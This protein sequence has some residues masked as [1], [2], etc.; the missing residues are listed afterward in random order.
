MGLVGF[1]AAALL[2]HRV[3]KQDRA[4]AA[5]A[6]GAPSEVKLRNPFELRQAISFGLLYGVVLLVAKAAQTYLGSGGLYV[7]AVLAGLTDV[8]AITLGVTE[9]HRG[10]LEGSVA[11][12][13]IVLAAATNTVVK[14]VLALSVGGRALGK[15]TAAILALTLVAGGLVVALRGLGG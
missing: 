10:G 3:R 8:D 7:S 4:A 6:E 11:A 1:G 15:P 13:A 14:S 9:L 12:N 2:Y 5:G